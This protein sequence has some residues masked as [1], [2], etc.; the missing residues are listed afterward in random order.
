MKTTWIKMKEKCNEC[1]EPLT[2][3]I[4]RV[5]GALAKYS[6]PY[7]EKCERCNSCGD[8]AIN[9]GDDYCFNCYKE[10]VVEGEE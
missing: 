4:T 2:Q 9:I 8:R 7:C 10:N 6:T 3:K 5:G 1:F